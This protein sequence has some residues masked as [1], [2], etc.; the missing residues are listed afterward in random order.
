MTTRTTRRYFS[1]GAN[2]VSVIGVGISVALGAPAWL[3]MLFGIMFIFSVGLLFFE[4]PQVKIVEKNVIED[5]VDTREEEHENNRDIR[6]DE[7]KLPPVPQ[8][9]LDE[10]K[11]IR[12]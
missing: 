4:Q 11:R 9:I 12:R 8:D 6:E 3:K 5:P 2:I 7:K 1:V 10:L